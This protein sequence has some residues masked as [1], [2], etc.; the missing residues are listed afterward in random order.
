MDASKSSIVMAQGMD[1]KL[2]KYYNSSIDSISAD[3][4]GSVYITGT[5][6][7]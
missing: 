2:G 4:D 3:S 6:K 7:V 5:E 1:G